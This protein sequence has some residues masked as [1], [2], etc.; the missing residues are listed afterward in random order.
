[1]T[2]Y[3]NALSDDREWFSTSE[4]TY[5]G[6]ADTAA[7]LGSAL[8]IDVKPLSF[9]EFVLPLP[10][11]GIAIIVRRVPAEAWR[12]P[13][14]NKYA[15]QPALDVD[16]NQLDFDAHRDAWM[17][18][19]SMTNPFR[20]L[21]GFHVRTGERRNLFFA[22]ATLCTLVTQLPNNTTWLKATLHGSSYLTFEQR[23]NLF[24]LEA[25]DSGFLGLHADETPTTGSSLPLPVLL[26]VSST[27]QTLASTPIKPDLRVTALPTIWAADIPVMR[28]DGIALLQYFVS[29]DKKKVQLRE[30]ADDKVSGFVHGGQIVANV[31]HTQLSQLHALLEKHAGL[32]AFEIYIYETL[33]E[34]SVEPDFLDVALPGWALPA[35]PLVFTGTDSFDGSMDDWLPDTVGFEY[36]TR[37][38]A[39]NVWRSPFYLLADRSLAIGET[40]HVFVQDTRTGAVIEKIS[41]SADKNNFRRDQW[42][43]ALIT[44]INASVAGSGTCIQVGCDSPES[45]EATLITPDSRTFAAMSE[46][47]RS[48]TTRLWSHGSGVRLTSTA[49]FMANLV[50]A[51]PLPATDLLPGT[52][53]NIQVRDASTSRLLENHVFAP[54]ESHLKAHQWSQALCHYLNNHSAWLRV[55]QL[56]SQSAWVVP[57]AENNAIWIPQESEI[58]VTLQPLLWQQYAPFMAIDAISAD[59]RVTVHVHDQATGE[60]MP[61][62][63]LV[64]NPSAKERAKNSWPCALAKALMNSPLSDFLRLGNADAPGVG[65]LDVGATAGVW[66]TA[67][68]PLRIWF[69]GPQ[70]QT[71]EWQVIS[72]DNE[73]PV[74]LADLYSAP[75]DAVQV[76][77]TDHHTQA[78]LAHLTYNPEVNG[79]ACDKATW[80]RGLYRALHADARF[81]VAVAEN[82]PGANGWDPQSGDY[83]HWKV[84]LPR[85][86]GMDILVRKIT[87]TAP[88]HIGQWPS[89]R[90]YANSLEA[91]KEYLTHAVDAITGQAK[92]GSPLKF[93]VS[94]DSLKPTEWV[95]KFAS[96]LKTTSW[97]KAVTL[98]IIS[99]PLIRIDN[100]VSDTVIKL[101]PGMMYHRW[102]RVR[103]GNE[104]TDLSIGDWYQDPSTAIVVTSIQ[105]EN[106]KPW[107][108]IPANDGSVTDKRSWLTGFY[109]ALY[110]QVRK[111]GIDYIA[112]DTNAPAYALWDMSNPETC[113]IWLRTGFGAI[114]VEYLEPSST[115][116]PSLV[117]SQAD[118]PDFTPPYL[119]RDRLL[120]QTAF[121]GGNLG[122]INWLNQSYGTSKRWSSA[123]LPASI[124]SMTNIVE[125]LIEIERSVIAYQEEGNYTYEARQL[126]ILES[127]VDPGHGS[128]TDRLAQLP[129]IYTHKK[130]AQALNAL[131]QADLEQTLHFR[132]SLDDG[133][134]ISEPYRWLLCF[135]DTVGSLHPLEC[136]G[137]ELSVVVTTQ[138]SAMVF[139]LKLLPQVFAAG[140]KLLCCH[141]NDGDRNV[142]SIGLHLPDDLQWPADKGASS[143]PLAWADFTSDTGLSQGGR[144][145]CIE[146]PFHG[147]VFLPEDTLC[148]DYSCTLQSEP[149]DVSGSVENGIDPRTGLFHAHYPIATLH[150]IEGLGPVVDLNIHYS[151]RRA[152]ECALG[153][154][155]A[156][157]FSSFDNRLRLLTL[158]TGQTIQLS[159]AEL[160]Q[161]CKEPEKALDK[162]YCRLS[163]GVADGK[164][165]SKLTCLKSLT[166]THF[167][168]RVE[169]L[170]KPTEHDGEEAGEAYRNAIKTRLNSVKANLTQWIDNE[171]IT[172]AQSD[173]FKTSR[174]SVEESLQDT[175]RK[176]FILTVS[177]ITSPQGGTLNFAWKGWKGHVRLLSVTSGD[178]CLLRAAHDQPVKAGRYS[179]TF[180]VW[181]ESAE[182]Y[183]VTLD[184][185]DC[186]LKVLTRKADSDS[187][188]I[189]QVR[190]GYQADHAL[191]RVLCAIQEEDG[192]LEVVSYKPQVLRP[193]PASVSPR[194][195][196][197]IE[198]DSSDHSEEADAD[199][200]P[201]ASL[202]EDPPTKDGEQD[203]E[204]SQFNEHEFSIALPRAARHTLV[205]GAAQPTISHRWR[206]NDYGHPFV[207]KSSFTSL[208][209][210]EV[211]PVTAAPSIRRV[212]AV[213][214]GMELPLAIVEETPGSVR[215]TTTNTY[216]DAD[217]VGDSRVSKLLL[218]QPICTAVS[219]EELSNPANKEPQA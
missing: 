150:G 46:D 79:Q 207:G 100:S 122:K 134:Q 7:K 74:L 195:R 139:R 78:A 112:V 3:L 39:T 35:P 72:N 145:V 96:A 6:I 191:D 197:D 180:Y 40:L 136:S 153:D 208:E 62:S 38:T 142:L 117:P 49:P 116:M 165:D 163:H 123:L 133:A 196:H 47:Q 143:M 213:K 29:A 149:Y 53:L 101:D 210:L 82:Q 95:E 42:P 172:D 15:I 75:Y 93:S 77:L 4:T 156:F 181:P 45:T 73:E 211:H 92:A 202:D 186:L 193:K 119:L 21:V 109:N 178:T 11:Q 87:T 55:G 19:L 183:Q 80:T 209:T 185:E 198:D 27:E 205:P 18:V 104:K 37:A 217:S 32:K 161:L 121:L 151:A 120:K 152:N 189:Q 90:A 115:T 164:L 36:T 168:H 126:S 176:A 14:D 88:A 132:L 84:W 99:D 199:D 12:D 105:Y 67:E 141:V 155:W 130:L 48:K 118:T 103:L 131:S 147:Q 58:R 128:L 162:G 171:E 138:Q 8:S 5:Q 206:W 218:S 174:N 1:M 33:I 81:P 59:Q 167:S 114:T 63:P 111:A 203:W 17:G 107:P 16:T 54:A 61:G 91:E 108:Y 10:E 201:A 110:C 71:L 26:S 43:S 184:I 158:G 215:R 86:A 113:S 144:Q 22:R 102:S 98:E 24:L 34:Q 89:V 94:Q 23:A 187:L 190:Y 20:R 212:W 76:L 28:C 64:F 41:L 83:S 192:S 159:A 30:K 85:Q 56:F 219:Y 68:M 70:S 125:D 194:D 148:T 188:P 173:N 44:R 129:D 51:M 182:R 170:A 175:S 25:P 214:N 124:Q 140:V 31:H 204:Y 200:A 160:Y 57:T 97:G 52:R 2:Q 65:E 216:P 69:D 179:S 60:P 146:R 50:C 13:E 169:V 177:R 106:Y 137:H 9:Y 154:G 135:D 66:W 157:R 166:I 127:M